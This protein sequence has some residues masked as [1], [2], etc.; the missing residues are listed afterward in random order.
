MMQNMLISDFSEP[1]FQEAFKIYFKEL[2][3]SVSDWDGLFQEMNVEKDNKAYVRIAENNNIIGFIQ[4]KPITLS[5]WFFEEKL[6]FIR[7][8][9]IAPEYR[10]QGH[11][12]ELLRLAEAYFAQN[13][14]SKIILTTDTAEKFYIKNGY[15][16]DRAF[17]AANQD[18]VFVKDL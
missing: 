14:I 7:E 10:S 3:I 17:T 5:N 13:D 2:R 4:F 6:G 9:W 8:F 11:G 1:T 18:E 15:R 12:T 16:K